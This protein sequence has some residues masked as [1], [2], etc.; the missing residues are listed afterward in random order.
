MKEAAAA[1]GDARI[2]ILSSV[3]HKSGIWD[4]GNMNGETFY[5][6]SRFY[7]NSKLYNV[8]LTQNSQ[9]SRHVGW[10]AFSFPFVPDNDGVF[11]ATETAE[12]WSDCFLPASWGGE[13][14]LNSVIHKRFD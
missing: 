12:R 11:F 4:P 7:G 3:A 6:L 13:F 2:V 5:S 9:C 10:Y 8:G 1:S 14:T